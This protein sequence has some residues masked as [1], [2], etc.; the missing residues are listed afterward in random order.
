M[1]STSNC[2]NN[3]WQGGKSIPRSF[4]CCAMLRNEVIR[5]RQT[6]AKLVY[7]YEMLVT[8]GWRRKWICDDNEVW[9][10]VQLAE[11]LFHDNHEHAGKV[12]ASYQNSFDYEELSPRRDVHRR[13]ICCRKSFSWTNSSSATTLANPTYAHR[14]R[15]ARSRFPSNLSPHASSRIASR[16]DPL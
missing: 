12:I 10:D 7:V 16:D 11:K 15:E 9:L 2:T 3:P 1:A 4:M 5:S 8:F 6:P 14:L 13:Y